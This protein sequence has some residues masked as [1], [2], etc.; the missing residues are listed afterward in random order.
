LLSQLECFL[1]FSFGVVPLTCLLIF[2]SSNLLKVAAKL[3]KGGKFIGKRQ[4]VGP[5]S[6]AGKKTKFSTLY[7]TRSLNRDVSSLD[8]GQ[9][10][11]GKNLLS[12]WL[13]V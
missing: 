4:E 3:K 8:R 5:S 7:Y 12:Y 2:A 11:Q 9:K 1:F 10:N 13:L 6:L